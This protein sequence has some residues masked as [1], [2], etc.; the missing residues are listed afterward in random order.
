[1]QQGNW[2][3]R[4]KLGLD[5]MWPLVLAMVHDNPSKRPTM[6]EVIVRFD[7]IVQSLDKSVLRS[8]VAL[9]TDSPL[10]GYFI[11]FAKWT[12]YLSAGRDSKGPRMRRRLQL[13]SLGVVS[14]S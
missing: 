1:M 14:N 5:F 3:H 9:Y 10:S 11:S 7:T 2:T 13:S 4:A 6:N 8:R 12:S